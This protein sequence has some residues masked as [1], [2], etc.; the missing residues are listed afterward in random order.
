MYFEDVRGLFGCEQ[1]CHNVVKFLLY[2]QYIIIIISNVATNFGCLFIIK[3]T[4][5]VTKIINTKFSSIIFIY[6]YTYF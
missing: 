5:T 4:N 3:I 2:K 6:T 1:L